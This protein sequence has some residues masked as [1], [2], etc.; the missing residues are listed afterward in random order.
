MANIDSIKEIKS[1]K[2]KLEKDILKL[3]T[4]FNKKHALTLVHVTAREMT[5]QDGWTVEARLDS[6]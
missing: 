3:I 5:K 4:D 2:C 6:V 1:N